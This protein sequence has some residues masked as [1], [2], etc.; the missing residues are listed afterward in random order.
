MAGK[1]NFIYEKLVTSD[2]DLTGLIAYGIYKK[3]KIEFI[4]KIKD[5]E[6]RNPTDEE[7][8]SFFIA[9]STESQLK[10]YRDQAET[11]L[12]EKLQTRKKGTASL[13]ETVPF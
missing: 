5:E 1:Y 11:I 4:A 10:K 12:A 7:C 3:H 8:Q 2:D 6:S 9:S 13:K